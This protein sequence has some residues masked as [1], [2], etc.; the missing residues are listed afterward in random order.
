[1]SE[2]AVKRRR[3]LEKDKVRLQRLLAERDLEIDGLGAWAKT[4]PPG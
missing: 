4:I 1:M 2:A 3:K